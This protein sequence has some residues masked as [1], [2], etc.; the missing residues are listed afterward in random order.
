M[1]FTHGITVWIA[2]QALNQIF[3]LPAFNQELQGG[4]IVH[5]EEGGLMGP[6][7][8]KGEGERWQET[9]QQRK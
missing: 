5:K 2:Q 7:R 9:L 8:E 6:K 3:W 4:D 1:E